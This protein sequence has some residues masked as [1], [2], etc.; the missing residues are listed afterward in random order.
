MV[1][2]GNFDGLH[3]GHREI[4]ESLKEKS[5]ALGVPTMVITFEPQPKE[6]FLQDKSTP[7][8][9][10]LREKLTAL[11]DIGVDRVLCLRFDAHLAQ[12]SA[13]DFIQDI[14]IAGLGVKAVIVGDDF[15]FGRNREG[16][17][18]MLKEVGAASGF[19]VESAP[20]FQIEGLRVSSTRIRELLGEGDLKM[21]GRLLGRP[22]FMSGRVAHGHKRGRMIGFPTANIFLH[23][24]AVPILGVYCV[25]TYGLGAEPIT[26]VANV[27][28][29][30]TVG[31][32]RSLL[33]VH[34]FDFDQE[35]YGQH[36]TV[37]FVKKLR[38]E[39]KFDSFDLLKEQI[40]I[41]AENAREY[42]SQS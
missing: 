15:T 10:R 12:M 16:D 31:G 32:T 7:R 3:L 21:A 1:T 13:G 25:R 26:G 4:L 37:E 19:Q 39:E 11:Q 33:E 20:T 29:R 2:I 34:L 38:D 28:T 6:Y 23:R 8:L 35:I 14:L 18:Q 42:F 27:G 17:F 40:L 22:Y 24:Q 30:P 9:M 41:D 5:V 36:V